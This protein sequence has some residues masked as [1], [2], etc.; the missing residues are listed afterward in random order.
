MLRETNH[1]EKKG[2]EEMV[3]LGLENLRR[4][5]VLKT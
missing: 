2:Y 3:F 5:P 1:W 4:L